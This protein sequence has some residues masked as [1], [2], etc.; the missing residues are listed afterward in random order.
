MAD[1]F[2]FIDT[3]KLEDRIKSGRFPFSQNLF[4]DYPLENIDLKQHQRYII[5]RVLT[6]G[7]TDDFYMLLKIY[8]TKEIQDALRKSKELDPKTIHF[9]S[10][11]FNLP[12]NEMH[13]SSF[14]R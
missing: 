13:V 2:K 3:E 10:W 14:Y 1:Y 12:K 8:S 5:E 6:R 11:Y 4:W 7:I 9:C